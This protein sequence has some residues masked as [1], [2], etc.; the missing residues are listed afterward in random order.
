MSK[1]S[2]LYQRL[3]NLEASLRERLM[4]QLKVCAAGRNDLLFCAR[5]F[6]PEQWPASLPT[7]LADG[8][9]AD[10]DAIRILRE[11]VNEPFRGSVAFQFLECCRKW[12]DSADHH[13]LAS[14]T[15]A[16][17][18]LAAILEAQL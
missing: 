15:M 9:L 7:D 5:R 4:P 13:R 14:R 18:L 2:K 16:E 8:I 3:D 6:F 17:E 10:I 1:T 12:S 11:K